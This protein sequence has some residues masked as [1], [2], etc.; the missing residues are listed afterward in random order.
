MQFSKYKKLIYRLKMNKKDCFY[1]GKIIKHHGMKGE[2]NIYADVDDPSLYESLP[3]MF[4]D[5]RT[6]L[7]P[8]FIE[9]IQFL[10]NKGI[11]K[12]QDVNDI[13]AASSFA[14]THIYLPLDLLPKLDGNKFYYHEVKGYK[15]VDQQLGE[16]GEIHDVL[17]YPSQALFQLF[18]KEKEVLIPITDDVIEKVDRENKQIKVNCPEGL[19]DVYLSE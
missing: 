1:F 2:V 16:L 18:I 9:N 6:G 19:L 17:E 12:I 7:I 11:V 4:L 8:Y 3:M 10:G 5:T 15:L 13:D 14:G